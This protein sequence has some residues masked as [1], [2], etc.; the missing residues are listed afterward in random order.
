[1]TMPGIHTLHLDSGRHS[2]VNQAAE[3]LGLKSAAHASADSLLSVVD[4]SLAGCVVTDLQMPERIGN[5]IQRRLLDLDSPL[6]VVFVAEAPTVSQTVLA[7]RGGAATVLE[8]PLTSQQLALEIQEA[9]QISDRRRKHILAVKDA[10]SR[11][12]TLTSRERETLPGVLSGRTNDAIASDLGVST[13]TIERRRRSILERLGVDC[14]A[15]VVSLLE[16]AGLAIFPFLEGRQA[17][18]SP[19]VLL[20]E[21]EPG[22]KPTAGRQSIRYDPFPPANWQACSLVA[23]VPARAETKVS[24]LEQSPGRLL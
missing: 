10:R 21:K 5:G 4:V 13:R 11:L 23:G 16:T 15:R 22:G 24:S 17:S 7:I 12:A 18:E 20:P 1:M 3:Q 19:G 8:G 2:L 14:F 6:A 9:V